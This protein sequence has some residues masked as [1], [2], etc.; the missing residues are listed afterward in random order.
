MGRKIPRLRVGLG[1]IL[2]ADVTLPFFWHRM[3]GPN[4]ELLALLKTTDRK[5]LQR[6][7]DP[8]G[9]GL[10]DFGRNRLFNRNVFVGQACFAFLKQVI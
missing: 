6:F 2:N 9:H 8:I 3:K 4:A 10:E 1:R 7:L 5:L